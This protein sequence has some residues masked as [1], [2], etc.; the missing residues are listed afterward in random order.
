MR[1]SSQDRSPRRPSATREGHPTIQARELTR[2]IAGLR[3]A[4]ATAQEAWVRLETS[5]GTLEYQI[6]W[7]VARREEAT[8][9]YRLKRIRAAQA[10]ARDG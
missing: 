2:A 4:E 8:A 6:E 7:G 5:P 3:G 9:A 1:P 10:A